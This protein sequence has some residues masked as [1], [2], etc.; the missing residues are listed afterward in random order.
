[1]D[2]LFPLSFSHDHLEVLYFSDDVY[3]NLGFFTY[4]NRGNW[5]VGHLRDG[6]YGQRLS[7][8]AAAFAQVWLFFG[9]LSEVAGLPVRGSGLIRVSE[10]GGRLVVTTERLYFYLNYQKE[11]SHKARN[12]RQRELSLRR[13][14]LCHDAMLSY[15]IPNFLVPEHPEVA[16]S[17]E[18]LLVTL[19]DTFNQIRQG[20]VG[21]TDGAC[22]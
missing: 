1:M 2:H 10:P 20:C 8:Q 7:T 3:G 19:V 16:I 4:H 11:S 5:D 12:D 17:V 14:K 22:T 15:T 18:I 21:C 9:A 13:A 6:N